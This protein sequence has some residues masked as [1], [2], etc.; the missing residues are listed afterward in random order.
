MGRVVT[1]AV[2]F[3]TGFLFQKPD[4]SRWFVA[5]VLFNDRG[6]WAVKDD[7]DG[8]EEVS[9][10]F[11]TTLDD[12][13]ATRDATYGGTTGWN[14]SYDIHS[15]SI[16]VSAAAIDEPA[17][18]RMG[19]ARSARVSG[20]IH[21]E[22]LVHLQHYADNANV[23]DVGPVD[24]RGIGWIGPVIARRIHK[25]Y[26]ETQ[27]LQQGDTVTFETTEFG[28][29]GNIRFEIDVFAPEL[30]PRARVIDMKRKRGVL[31]ALD[32]RVETDFFPVGQRNQLLAYGYAGNVGPDGNNARLEVDQFRFDHFP[33]T[34]IYP[35]RILNGTREI[36]RFNLD[37]RD[38]A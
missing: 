23:Y 25:Y 34:G 29:P 32:L 11:P 30:T 13:W 22:E 4:G 28:I 35:F 26:E 7:F 38:T 24:D 21:G 19:F 3:S 6:V 37:W 33:P 16:G 2:A 14:L 17:L 5:H 18:L 9:V 10:Q 15:V 8:R 1:S 36:I 27:E 20:P 12:N 31:T